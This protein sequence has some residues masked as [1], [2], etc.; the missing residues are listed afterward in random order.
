[1]FDQIDKIERE[2]SQKDET[3]HRI[4][5]WRESKNAQ[6][7]S[8][9]KAG[10]LE[11]PGNETQKESELSPPRSGELTPL[12]SRAAGENKVEL[13]HPWPEWIELMER[14]VQQNY[15]DHK[16]RDEG[17]MISALGFDVG[18][19]VKDEEGS[20]FTRDLKTVQTAGLNFGKDRFDILRFVA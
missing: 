7:A 8:G 12:E 9:Q 2:R 15:F 1:M 13:V 17:R 6:H 4:R 18:E 11:S 14:L 19:D 10:A 3:L 16:R 20:D 5:A